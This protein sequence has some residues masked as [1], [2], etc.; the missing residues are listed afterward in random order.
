MG[1]RCAVVLAICSIGIAGC[2]SG[3][4]FEPYDEV[5]VLPSNAWSCYD[6]SDPHCL[7]TPPPGDPDDRAPGVYLGDSFSWSACTA[8]STD[9]DADGIMDFCEYQIALV[10]RPLLA[11]SIYDIYLGRDMY[12]AVDQQA[13]NQFKIAYM[14]GYYADGGCDHPVSACN[15]HWGDSEFL[16]SFVSFDPTSQHW[17]LDTQIMSAHYGEGINIDNTL[18]YSSELEYPTGKSRYYNRVYV[19]LGKHANYPTRA[20][21]A[22]KTVYHFSQDHCAASADDVR[23]DVDYSRNVGS[24]G[25]QL[26]NKTYSTGSRFGPEWFWTNI[27][28]CGWSNTSAYRPP[29]TCSTSY[30]AILTT[31]MGNS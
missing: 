23:F 24:V 29:G 13:T 26:I 19:S 2:E 8:P 17:R 1:T 18:P 11:T 7:N 20:I 28:F 16:I 25:A 30:Y 6:D 10:F 4:A 31:F 9:L 3:P 21:C 12:W 15:G 14:F 27:L 22:S 5:A